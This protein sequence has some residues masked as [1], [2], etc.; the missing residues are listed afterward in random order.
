MAS[1][2]AVTVT[3]TSGTILAANSS[4]AGY[5]IINPPS[6]GQT[7]WVNIDGATATAAPPCIPIAQGDSFTWRGGGVVTAIAG[8]SVT[9][10]VAEH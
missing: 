5:A 9:I 2:T 3:A 10:T 4:R 6:S 1:A 8:G 7:V